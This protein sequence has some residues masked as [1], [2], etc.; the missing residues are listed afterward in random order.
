MHWS[1]IASPETSDSR[2]TFRTWNAVGELFI[3]CIGARSVVSS[4]V[5]FTIPHFT[6]S[7]IRVKLV[8]TW[9]ITSNAMCAISSRA[10]IVGDDEGIS[11]IVAL[12]HFV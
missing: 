7:N 5:L 4:T 9:V 3:F 10:G 11:D 8:A 1:L 6:N 12:T 2:T